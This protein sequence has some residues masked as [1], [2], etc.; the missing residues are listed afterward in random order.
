MYKY[1]VFVSLLLAAAVTLAQDQKIY[2]SQ[3][4]GFRLQYPSAYDLKVTADCYL[5]FQKG[6]ETSFGLRVDDR[7]I[8]MLYQMVH[9]PGPVVYRVGQDPYRKLARETR[10]NQKLFYRYARHEAQN[11]CAA[12]GPD[13]SNF[14]RD[15]KR[16]KPFTSRHGLSCL[17]LYPVLIREDYAENTKQQKVVGPVFGVF[18]PKKD[19]P[20]LL[21]IS[22][23]YGSLA[24]PTLV[25][26]MRQ[27]IDSLKVTP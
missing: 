13:G 20:L 15:I 12:D 18:L 19:L 10:H 2:V 8:E 25:Q 11:W 6:V 21:I 24:S 16:E 26:D 9:G 5:G 3:K 14:C 4:Y 27:V 1:I 17:E 23:R 7:F 22:P